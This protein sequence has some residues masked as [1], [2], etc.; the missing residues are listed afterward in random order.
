MFV[1][2]AGLGTAVAGVTSGGHYELP[3]RR[4]CVRGRCALRPRLDRERGPDRPRTDHVQPDP[5]G[6]RARQRGSSSTTRQW[7]A[8]TAACCTRWWCRPGASALRV[9]TNGELVPAQNY[10]LY[11]KLGGAPSV[12]PPDYD[13]AS[14]GDTSFE[15]CSFDA[16]AAGEW[17]ILVA[18]AAPSHGEY[19]LTVSTLG[20]PTP[21]FLLAARRR[22]RRH[23]D[24]VERRITGPALSVQLH[25]RSTHLRRVGAGRHARRIG[26]RCAARGLRRR[27]Q[28]RR[29]RDRLSLYPMAYC[30]Y[31]IGSVSAVR[32]W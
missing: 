12:E 20:A 24:A 3:S 13:C 2:V 28:H 7:R 30:S 16:P 1:D 5:A 31:D 29:R 32:C 26:D 9:T 15:A 23:H 8:P 6:A 10:D 17:S 22:R 21:G 19:D 18:N 25:R 14:T 4:Q 27:T 11:V